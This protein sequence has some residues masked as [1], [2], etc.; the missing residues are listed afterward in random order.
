[1]SVERETRKIRQVVSLLWGRTI[2]HRQHRYFRGFSNRTGGIVN[3]NEKTRHCRRG[4]SRLPSTIWWTQNAENRVG[5]TFVMSVYARAVRD[6]LCEYHP[7]DRGAID[8]RSNL[9]YPRSEP[10]TTRSTRRAMRMLCASRGSRD[11]YGA[12]ERGRGKPIP[13]GG[14]V[15]Q[16]PNRVKRSRT[17]PGNLIRTGGIVNWWHNGVV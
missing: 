16:R 15:N 14:I 12:Y 17:N 4:A 1:M 10:A 5:R 8:G 7:T 2:P 9:V 3:P 6:S 13:T 11:V